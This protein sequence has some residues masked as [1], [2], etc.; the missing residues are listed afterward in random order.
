MNFW[1]VNEGKFSLLAP[2]AQ[3]LISAPLLQHQKP[4]VERAFFVCVE[5]IDSREINRLTKKFKQRAFIKIT[6][7]VFFNHA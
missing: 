5:L 2:L 3:D 1:T 6:V 4:Y 7:K